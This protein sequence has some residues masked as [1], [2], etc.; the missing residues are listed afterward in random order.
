VEEND[1]VK[2]GAF[3][4]LDIEANHYFRI[5]KAEWD[6]I[7][8]DPVEEVSQPGHGVKVGTIVC[9]EGQVEQTLLPHLVLMWFA[10]ILISNS[11]KQEWRRLSIFTTH[12]QRRK[13]AS[14]ATA[15]EW[16]RTLLCYALLVL[17]SAHPT[18]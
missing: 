6:S 7:S 17:P 16:L 1:H 4:T 8:L 12:M 14:S 5:E 2:M 15:H 13:R 18:Y 9:G 10:W 11:I 3:H